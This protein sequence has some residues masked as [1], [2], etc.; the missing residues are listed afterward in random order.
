MGVYSAPVEPSL[1]LALRPKRSTKERGRARLPDPELIKV[2][3]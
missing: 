1:G 2:E 3:W